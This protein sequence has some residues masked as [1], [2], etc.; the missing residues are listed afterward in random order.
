MMQYRYIFPIV[1]VAILTGACTTTDSADL[2]QI[3]H[4]ETECFAVS[5]KTLP[6]MLAIKCAFTNLKDSAQSIKVSA[7]GFPKFSDAINVYTPDEISQSKL[8]AAQSHQDSL[9]QMIHFVSLPSLMHSPKSPESGLIFLLLSSAVIAGKIH[10]DHQKNTVNLIK[11]YQ[12]QWLLKED[13]TRLDA[14]EKKSLLLLID[15]DISQTIPEQ[16]KLSF[17][18][19]SSMVKVVPLKIDLKLIRARPGLN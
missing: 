6:K 17:T 15:R 4:I 9:T 3:N 1:L 5:D 13:Q 2:S 7:I 19:P 10:K 8:R 12:N 11:D 16:I 18:K 14:F